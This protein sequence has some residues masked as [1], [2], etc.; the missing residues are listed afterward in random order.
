MTELYADPENPVLPKSTF[1]LDL[2]RAALVVID[3]QND[4]LHPS[5]VSWPFFG[6]SVVENNTVSHIGQLFEAAKAADITVAISPH[7]YYPCD[8]HWQ[9]GGPLEKTMHAINM[10]GRKGQFTVEEFEGSGADFLEDYK[11]TST[12]AKPSLPRRTRSTAP[13][14]TTSFSN[15]ANKVCHKSSW[16]AW[17]PICALKRICGN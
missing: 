3:P 15:C 12:T 11:S 2:K 4:F 16:P 17:P 5:G 14:R 10:F 9:F 6:E 8:H 1:Q 13:R 7:F